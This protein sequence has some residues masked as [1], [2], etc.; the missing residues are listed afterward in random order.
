[1]ADWKHS[2]CACGKPKVGKAK[3]CLECY[4][5]SLRPAPVQTKCLWC[6]QIF[7]ASQDRWSLTHRPQKYCSR[8]CAQHGNGRLSSAKRRDARDRRIRSKPAHR[9][10]ACRAE[11]PRRG[12]YC[13]CFC[14]DGARLAA[15]IHQCRR[16]RSAQAV[17][18]VPRTFGCQRCGIT[19][20]VR[21][22]DK[23]RAYCSDTCSRKAHR[24]PSKHMRRART[25]GRASDRGI[26]LVKVCERDG[27]TCRI[28]GRKVKRHAH[29]NH[30]LSP[31]ID[32]IIPLSDPASPGHVW[33]NVQC[34]HRDCN[35]M[36]SG[37]SFGQL[38]LGGAS[39]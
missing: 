39:L 11:M 14:R 2:T 35:S 21:Y 10:K 27:W 18:Q 34:A 37:K 36:K 22:G 20:E 6:H 33:S 29:Y 13:S 16:K 8:D 25:R 4:S 19:V 32:H 1:M 15:S 5:A 38:W 3:R 30:G 24:A 17:F 7:I 31:S 9:C 28:C 12:A 26:T 23:R